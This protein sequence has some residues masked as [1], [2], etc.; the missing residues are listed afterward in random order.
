MPNATEHGDRLPFKNSIRRGPNQTPAM[1]TTHSKPSND[2]LR[3]WL[4]FI[5]VRQ[6]GERWSA[7][8]C[9]GAPPI[10]ATRLR[11]GRSPT[12][13]VSLSGSYQTGSGP[14]LMI[15]KRHFAYIKVLK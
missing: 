9:L 6:D 2:W 8:A 4:T 10:H 3:R 5:L 1:S 13:H 11:T 14:F 15:A 12:G 7:A